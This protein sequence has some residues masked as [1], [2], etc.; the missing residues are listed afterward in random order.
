MFS[1]LYNTSVKVK[2]LVLTHIKSSYKPH[3]LESSVVTV[4]KVPFIKSL[5]DTTVIETN[6]FRTDKSYVNVSVSVTV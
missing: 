6:V 1:R 5:I 4:R 2:I 3:S